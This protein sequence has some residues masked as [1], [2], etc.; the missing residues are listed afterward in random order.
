LGPLPPAK[1]A[2][3][4]TI[5]ASSASTRLSIKTRFM[6]SLL[7]WDVWTLARPLAPAGWDAQGDVAL[8]LASTLPALPAYGPLHS[9][10]SACFQEVH[11][12]AVR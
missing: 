12:L 7:E 8:S 10:Y 2:V 6:C 5:A 1:A 3:L 4:I 11:T 9:F